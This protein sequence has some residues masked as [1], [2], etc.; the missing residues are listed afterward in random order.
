M[1]Q[2]CNK[3]DLKIDTKKRQ[4]ELSEKQR[5]IE[6]L[7]SEHNLDAILISHNENVAWATAGQVDMRVGVRRETGAGSLL[8][9]RE[10]GKYY[11]TTENEA[12]RFA[13][14][15]SSSLTMSLFSSP[16]TP[17]R[18]KRRSGRPQCCIARGPWRCLQR[19]DNSR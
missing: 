10:G 4:V 7:L 16:G 5:G 2:N 18:W 17:I 11:L 13:K 6:L 19:H 8:V 3:L 9:T 14:E 1:V 12:N 15:S